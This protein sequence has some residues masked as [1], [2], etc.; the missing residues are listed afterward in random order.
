MYRGVYRGRYFDCDFWYFLREACYKALLYAMVRVN[1]VCMY[2]LPAA[3][4]GEQQ[5]ERTL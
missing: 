3:W 1:A 5:H 2:L 4:C